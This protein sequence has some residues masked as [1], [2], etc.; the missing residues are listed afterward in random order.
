MSKNSMNHIYPFLNIQKAYWVA[1]IA[2]GMIISCSSKQSNEAQNIPKKNISKK[3]ISSTHLTQTNINIPTNLPLQKEKMNDRLVFEKHSEAYLKDII[4]RMQKGD[5]VKIVCFGNSI[6]KGYKVG[7]Y[8][9]VEHPYPQSLEK[10]LQEHFKNPAIQVIN[11]GHNGWKSNQA[12]EYLP[13]IIAQK[14][15]LVML[16]FG[17][18]DAYSRFSL[19]F[20]ETKITQIIAQLQQNQIKVLLLSP[21]PIHTSLNATV[22]SYAEVLPKIAENKNIAFFDLHQALNEKASQE[23]VD[24]ET[25]LPDD[26]HLADD[27]YIWIAELIFH[28]LKKA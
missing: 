16:K 7:S 18:N 2:F 25:L 22:L 21:T 14:P 20:Y 12:L 1:W 10:M 5:A 3:A 11:E 6:T 4:H 28:Y 17:I 9:T 23:K 8:Q 24:F 26:I 13:H 19:P 15:D 27:K